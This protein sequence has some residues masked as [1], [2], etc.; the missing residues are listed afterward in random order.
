M[1]SS[2]QKTRSVGSRLLAEV[3][4][5]EK[6]ERARIIR[7]VHD[8]GLQHAL[9]ALQE[10][11]GIADGDP[12]APAALRRDLQEIVLSLRSLTQTADDDSLARLS[13][14]AAV[15]RLAELAERRG[16]MEVGAVVDPSAEGVHDELV[17]DAVRE[18]LTNT[19]RH[20]RASR[21]DV[22]VADAGD[23]I[24]ISV[25]DDGLGFSEEALAEAQRT[26]HMGV[27]GLQRTADELGGSLEHATGLD[28]RGVRFTLRLP[29]EALV[30][31]ESLEEQLQEE[32]RW[33]AALVSALQDALVVVRNGDIV[34]VNDE[35]CALVALKREALLGTHID[36]VEFWGGV[37]PFGAWLTEMQELA[38]GDQRVSLR[39]P[40]DMHFDVLASVARIDDG[41]G[42]DIGV[43]VLL[44]QLDEWMS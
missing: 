27:R 14:G 23:A 18:L 39:R 35:F 19:I 37:E 29:R 16:R 3:L 10:L 22:R 31:Q 13:L 34:Q 9:A 25:A 2:E 33:S 43:L 42:G 17:R 12:E 5:A 41:R 7:Q 36:D 15:A 32:R 20:A 6:A 28:G 8:G 30:A 4:A 21:V 40:D 24:T 38:R 44:K 26:G 11:D 1:S